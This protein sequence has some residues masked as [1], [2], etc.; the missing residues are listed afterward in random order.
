MVDGRWYTIEAV[1]APIN[2]AE[3]GRESSRD[4]RDPVKM[5]EAWD[6]VR[7]QPW[8]ANY[9]AQ[10][11]AA[12]VDKMQVPDYD[13]TF[14]NHPARYHEELEQRAANGDRYAQALLRGDTLAEEVDE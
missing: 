3:L 10:E 2:P 5:G 13:G 6:W 14:E 8:A 1:D 9:T 4:L 12:E 11:V 7:A